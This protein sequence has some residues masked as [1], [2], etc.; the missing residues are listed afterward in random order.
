MKR[1]YLYHQPFSWVQGCWIAIGLLL[2]A[3][4]ILAGQADGGNLVGV[5]KPLGLI[6]MT[7][8]I[9]NMVVCVAKY[10]QMDGARWLIADSMAA[11]L[12]SI[13]P[14]FNQMSMPI[15]IPFF[16]GMWE[17]FSGIVKVI[18]SLELKED[19]MKCWLGFAL[20]GWVELASGTASLIKPLDDL[21]GMER[22]VSIIFFVQSC[23][24]FLKATMYRYL[25]QKG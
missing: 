1:H 21:V 8:G 16:F 15:L 9:I 12:L 2:F 7:A 5:A 13:F 6:M 22:V 18:D 4:S 23:G 14:L 10:H 19:H 17:L 24:F 25:I 3:G 20:I 11:M